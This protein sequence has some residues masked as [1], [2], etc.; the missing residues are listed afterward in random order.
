MIAKQEPGNFTADPAKIAA[1]REPPLNDFMSSRQ[2]Q[3]GKE[4]PQGFTVPAQVGLPKPAGVV[5]IDPPFPWQIPLFFD[6]C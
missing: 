3:G 2:T 1:L 4:F 6:Y 5:G